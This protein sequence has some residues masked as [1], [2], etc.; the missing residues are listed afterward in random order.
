MNLKKIGWVVAFG[1]FTFIGPVASSYGCPLEPILG[2]VCELAYST[3]WC[4]K[5][6]ALANGA[7]MHINQNQA[8]FSLLSNRYGGDGRNTF[9]LPNFTDRMKRDQ[10]TLCIAVEGAYPERP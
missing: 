7:T 6:F 1:F 8:L 4:P 2:S 5:G 10:V 9:A 3:N